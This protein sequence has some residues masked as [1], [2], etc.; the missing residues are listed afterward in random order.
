[1]SQVCVD[2]SISSDQSTVMI[3][4]TA[5]VA[6]RRCEWQICARC[7]VRAQRLEAAVQSKPATIGGLVR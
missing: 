3:T 5:M 4:Q 7:W 2:C 1:M 6:G